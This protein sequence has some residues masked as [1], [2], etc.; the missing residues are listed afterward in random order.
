ML[1]IHPAHHAATTWRDFFIY[2]AT[3]TVGLFIA[4]RPGATVEALHHRH[5]RHLLEENLRDELRRRK[6]QSPS[7]KWTNPSHKSSWIARFASRS[8]FT[9]ASEQIC[10]CS[11][12]SIS[13]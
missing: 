1:D 3:I 5:Q 2:I 12:L 4:P 6:L 8:V 13:G 11:C 10:L 7:R 9:S